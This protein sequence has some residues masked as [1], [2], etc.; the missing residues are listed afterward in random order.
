MRTTPSV[1]AFT[2]D[3]EILIGSAAKRQAIINS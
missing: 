1:I 3:Y 2:K